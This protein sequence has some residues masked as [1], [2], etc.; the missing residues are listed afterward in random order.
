MSEKKL[1]DYSLNP[2]N[3]WEIKCSGI[4]KVADFELCFT[5]F[6]NKIADTKFWNSLANS[7]DLCK[8]NFWRVVEVC[9]FIFRITFVKKKNDGLEIAKFCFYYNILD[10]CEILSIGVLEFADFKFSVTFIK[11]QNRGPKFPGFF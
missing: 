2:L 8:I 1:S 10:F 3:L 7:L 6:K 9:Y 4:F 11:K 5:F